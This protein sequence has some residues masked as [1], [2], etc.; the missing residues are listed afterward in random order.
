[1]IKQN[2]LLVSLAV[3]MALYGTNLAAEDDDDV[4]Q[5]V[6]VTAQKRTERITEVPIAIS[7]FQSEAIDQ[8]GIQELRELGDFI[9]NMTV[10]QGT[11][12][13]SRILIRGVGA[14]SRNIGFD[15][16]VGVYLDGVYLGQGPSVNQDLVDLERVEVL[17]GPQGTL[18]GKN[19]VAGAVSLVS[20]KPSGEYEGKGTLGFGNFNAIEAK[21]SVDFSL[22][23]TVSAKAAFSSRTRDG[24]IKNVYTEGQLPTTL[25]AVVGGVRIFDIPL[26]FP[27]ETSNPPDTSDKLN[28]QDTQ[29]YRIQLRFQPSDD[30]DINIA[31]DGLDSERSPVLAQAITSTFG[32][33]LDNFADASND[34]V[35]WSFQGQET[36]DIFGVNVNVEY[37]FE[38]DYMLR[39]ITGFRDTEITYGND[40][41]YSPLDFIYL[42]YKDSYDQTTQE[43]Q[44]ISPDDAAFKYVVGLYYYT[45]EANSF[46]NAITGNAGIFFD[47]PVGGGSINE[48]KVDTDSTAIY[49][50]GSYEFNDEWKLGFGGRYSKETKDVNWLLDGSLGGVFGIGCTGVVSCYINPNEPDFALRIPVDNISALI[51]SR[52]DTNFSPAISLNYAFSEWTNGYVKYSTGFKSGGFNLDFVNQADLVAGLDF[53]KETVTSIEFGIKTSLLDNRLSINMAYFDATYDDYQVNQ[54]FDVGFDSSTGTQITSIRITNAAE[55]DTSGFEFEATFKATDA[56][57]INGSLGILDAT[58]A[59]FPG[60]TSVLSTTETNEDGSPKRVPVDADGN[61]LPG[62]ADFNASLGIQYYSSFDSISSDLL[63]RLDIT[64]TGDYFTT[65]ENE[66]TRVLSGTHPLTFALDLQNSEYA[67]AEPITVRYGHIQATTILNGRIGLIDQNG[68]WEV[69]LWGRNLTDEDEAVDSFREF[70][71]TLVNTPRTPRTYGIEMIYNFD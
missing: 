29:S 43:F 4:G 32:D 55:V 21:V 54:F 56:L 27:I 20:K 22:S 48:G 52:E 14:A 50:S 15:S 64:H 60:G 69:Y 16:R 38:N 10:T 23:D 46:R 42:D 28:S 59:S 65:I 68:L 34:E 5:V 57:T 63:A 35:N 31:I 33:T 51:D 1:V 17:R 45:Q 44:L 71:G 67:G 8:T 12:F 2:K 24:Y 6:I 18:F 13:N 53:D 62:A 66:K 37:S 47:A 58:F 49:V 25:N 39:S 36:R 40:T 7:V 61:S 30:L 3:S 19:T 9:P 11:D 41:D 70:F 26:P